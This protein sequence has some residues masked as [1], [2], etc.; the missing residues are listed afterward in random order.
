[1]NSTNLLKSIMIME[2]AMRYTETS[3]QKQKILQTL[4]WV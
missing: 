1:M 2:L 3:A 4:N